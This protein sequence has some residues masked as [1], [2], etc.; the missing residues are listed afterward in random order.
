MICLLTLYR[1]V[2]SGKSLPISGVIWPWMPWTSVLQLLIALAIN[3]ICGYL[4]LAS[5]KATLPVLSRMGAN[6]LTA[7][8]RIIFTRQHWPC[9][10]WQGREVEAA[11]MTLSADAPLYG[12]NF[13]TLCQHSE[14]FSQ[15]DP[16]LC[17]AS[18]GFSDCW[19]SWTV[20]RLSSSTPA[21]VQW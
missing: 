20:Q 13:R 18:S 7:L 11:S 15:G 5:K 3:H 12:H 21:I 4:R 14:Q 2:P 9:H 8:V 1:M 16:G 17:W 19:C 6:S 10:T